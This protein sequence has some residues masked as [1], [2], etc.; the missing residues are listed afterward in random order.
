MKRRMFFYGLTFFVMLC[1]TNCF[2]VLNAPADEIVHNITELVPG[3][4]YEITA[5]Y[6]NTAGWDQIRSCMLKFRTPGSDYDYIGLRW[7]NDGMIKSFFKLNSYSE[8]YNNYVPDLTSATEYFSAAVALMETDGARLTLTWRF[9]LRGDN[10]WHITPHDA[11]FIGI[12]MTDPSGNQSGYNEMEQPI[13][14]YEGVPFLSNSKRALYIWDMGVK[15]VR[16]ADDRRDFFS[17]VSA[18]NSNDD[19]EINTIFLCLESNEFNDEIDFNDEDFEIMRSFIAEAHSRGFEIQY[20]SGDPSWARA[21]NR[22]DAEAHIQKVITYNSTVSNNRDKFDGI[23]FDI[24]PHLLDDWGSNKSA[25]WQAYI[26]NLTYFQS[27]VDNHNDGNSD[28]LKFSEAITY[29]YEEVYYEGREGYKQII[30]IVDSVVIMNYWTCYDSPSLSY[31]ELFYAESLSEKPEIYVAFETFSEELPNVSFWHHGNE[32]LEF[33]TYRF[34]RCYGNRYF[35]EDSD[36]ETSSYEPFVGTAVHF[37]EMDSQ[38]AYRALKLNNNPQPP[39][40]ERNF[41]PVCTIVSPQGSTI[42][43]DSE[44]VYQVYDNDTSNLLIS[45]YLSGDGFEQENIVIVE[46]IPVIVDPETH[47]ASGQISLSD[48]VL[49]ITEG[50]YD[51]KMVVVEN[52]ENEELSSYDTTNYQVYIEVDSSQIASTIYEHTGGTLIAYGGKL[53]IAGAYSWNESYYMSGRNKLEIYDPQTNTWTEGAELPEHRSFMGA[54]VLDE[55]IYFIGG[56]RTQ[57]YPKDNVWKYNPDTDTWDTSLSP[58]P[59]AVF[60]IRTV[61]IDDT[62]YMIHGG[63]FSGDILDTYRYEKSTDSW[64]VECQG[65]PGDEMR[66]CTGQAYGGKIYYFGS[67]SSHTRKTKIYDPQ[68]GDISYGPDIPEGIYHN[69][70]GGHTINSVFYEDKAFVFSLSW[71]G[72]TALQGLN[73][74][75]YVYSFVTNSWY[76]IDISQYIPVSEVEII[77]GHGLALLGDEVYF[78]DDNDFGKRVFKLNLQDVCDQI[79]APEYHPA[80]TN[81]DF[82]ISG[83]EETAYAT[84][85]LNGQLWSDGALINIDYLTN[86]GYISLQG[87]GSYTLDVQAD[88]PKYW[89]PASN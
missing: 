43:T 62:P 30:D 13:Y 70:T 29:W 55:E 65:L 81:E 1:T 64:I 82:I 34:N 73:P 27:L 67:T 88:K 59:N 41:A 38:Q 9:I 39:G 51:I 12:N 61:M 14:Y 25:I 26:S 68:T 72:E 50:Y 75:T 76:V 35:D 31:D 69:P 44:V 3:V 10:I 11:L 7:W 87:D 22:A 40:P 84:S 63:N 89:K 28:D 19:A 85:W 24:E 20:L 58:L 66:A 2:A 18:P 57:W 21:E 23:H 78:Y 42:A 79:P 8:G 49:S 33:M 5:N 16:S 52:D 15:L 77:Y 74:N 60:D 54:F 48:Y 56:Q 86:A 83:S 4:E 36:P 45:F 6:Y 37:Y 32:A 53:Y 47:Q 17:F 46:N 80:D 71:A